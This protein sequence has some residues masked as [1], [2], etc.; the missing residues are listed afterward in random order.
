MQVAGRLSVAGRAQARPGI[1]LGADL[2]AG[3]P[4]ETDAMLRIYAVVASPRPAGVLS[5]C[6]P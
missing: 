5:A 4:A 6:V 3:F 2:I 1:V